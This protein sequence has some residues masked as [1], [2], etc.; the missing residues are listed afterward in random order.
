ML[1]QR[2]QVVFRITFFFH[3]L[4]AM[5][6]RNLLYSKGRNPEKRLGPS[7]VK[8]HNLSNTNPNPNTNPNHN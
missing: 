7:S 8:L 2:R 5:A 3:F 4:I 1:K 6:K